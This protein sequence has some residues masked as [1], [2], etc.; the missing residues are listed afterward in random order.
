M[1]RHPLS[2]R[3]MMHRGIDLAVPRGTEVHATADGV[4]EAAG[5]NRGY[6]NYIK[7][8]HGNGKYAT[9]YAHLKGFARGL[10]VRQQVVRGQ[11]IGYVGSTGASTGSHLHYEVMH[12]DNGQWRHL[13]PLQYNHTYGAKKTVCSSRKCGIIDREIAGLRI[14]VLAPRNR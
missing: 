12:R 14:D 10:K 13:D 1:R 7:L 9:L 5:Y 6:G 11:I 4:V 8:N 2:G 3:H